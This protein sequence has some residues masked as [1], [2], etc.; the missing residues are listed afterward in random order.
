MEGLLEGAVLAIFVVLLFLRDVRATA[1]SALAIPM[2]AIPAFWF[3]SMLSINLNEL[4]LL[5]L[6]LVAGV[7]VDDAIVE[8]ENIVRHMRMG[9]SAYQAALDAADEIGLA[10]LA[11]T[12]SIVAVFL[13][14][15]LMPGISGQFFKAFGFTVV[16]AVLMSL[17]VA[18]M[19]TPLIAAY[20]LRSKGI[21]PHASGRAMEGYLKVLGWSLNT[22]KAH[23]YALRHPGV[24]GKIKSLRF[25]HRLAM[26]G[27]GIGALVLTGV[28]IATLPMT[29]QP[30]INVDTSTVQVSL[31]PG[32]TLQQTED[33][34][35][36][37]ARL[38]GQ[39][40]A[41]QQ[42]FERINVG[43]GS[44]DLKLKKDRT[45]TS[46]EFERSLAPKLADIADARVNFQSQNGGGPGGASRDIMLYLG[47]D[48]PVKLL[49]AANKIAAEMQNLPEL[50]APRAAGD[51]PTP[52]IVIKPRFDLAA[53]LGV[54]TAALSQT[55][56][57][58]TLGDIEQ[59]SAKFA[60]S[61]RQIPIQ[62]SLAEN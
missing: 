53:D 11:T 6:S 26:V 42:T 40:P 14:V 7:L 41:V 20:F 47:G 62:V 28:L 23:A 27:A 29:F 48:D 4:S 13:P 34:T 17:L 59:N 61:D 21:Q 31:P 8:I 55:I 39:N 52:E 16:L 19:V 49:A 12:M 37:V 32:S 33:V 38:V 2:S 10:V 60:L 25:D 46:T 35:D 18:R 9:K 5:A 54:T 57:I 44:V 43:S 51:L 1:I 50:R 30:P 36:R 24:W 3:M 22:A 56:R 58:A 15:A 45:V